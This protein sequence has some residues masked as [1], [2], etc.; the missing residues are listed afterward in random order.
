MDYLWEQNDNQSVLF[1]WIS[2][3]SDETFDHLHIRLDEIYIKYDNSVLDLLDNESDKDKRAVKLPGSFLL[4]QNFNNDQ[5]E[6]AFKRKYFTCQVCFTDKM[7]KDCMKFHEC[8]H[9]FCNEC[10]RGYFESQIKSGD[11]KKLI[12]P[13]VKCDTEALQAQVRIE[14]ILFQIQLYVL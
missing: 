12:C 3:L 9:V 7:G 13:D 4:F 8:E 11:I 5:I 6:L 1:T 2:F 10:M 14:S